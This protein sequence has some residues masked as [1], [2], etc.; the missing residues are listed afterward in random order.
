M[1]TSFYWLL[2][3]IITLTAAVY[4]RA[5]GPTYEKKI[6]I[7]HNGIVHNIELIRSHSTSKPAPVILE[8]SDF[9]IAGNLF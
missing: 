8:V 3:I 6:E 9:N 7:T 2:A 5:T 1:K 4:Q